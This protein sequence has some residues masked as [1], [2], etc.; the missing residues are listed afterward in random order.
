MGSRIFFKKGNKLTPSR[1][2][3]LKQESW[4]LVLQALQQQAD[5]P[6]ATSS[7][8]HVHNSALHNICRRTN[9][10]SDGTRQGR[11]DKVKRHAVLHEVRGE[12]VLLEEIVRNKLRGVHEDGSN[13]QYVL[14]GNRFSK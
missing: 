7:S 6:M 13:L 11:G 5:R 4:S 10:G 2:P 12:D 14:L 9:S 1:K 3:A 8:L